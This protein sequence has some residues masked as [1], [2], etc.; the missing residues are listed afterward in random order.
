[1]HPRPGSLLAPLVGVLLLRAPVLNNL[2]YR[3]PWFY[4]G[5][6]AVARAATIEVFGWFY[7]AVRFHSVLP[8]GW[9]ADVLARWAAACVLRYALLVATGAAVFACVRRF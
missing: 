3:D 7:Y 8:T 5:Y 1:M 2:P 6:G 4:P 9:A